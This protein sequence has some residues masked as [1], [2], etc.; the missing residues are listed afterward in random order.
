VSTM[1]PQTP[2]DNAGGLAVTHRPSS[3]GV[4][5]T[6][7][8]AGPRVRRHLRSRQPAPTTSP[9]RRLGGG[10]SGL[11]PAAG[12]ASAGFAL[13]AARAGRRAGGS[14]GR[15]AADRPL[16]L[17]R[18]SSRSKARRVAVATA[19][20]ALEC[21][22]P[23]PCRGAPG[24]RGDSA[25]RP[26]R[27][28]ADRPLDLEEVTMRAPAAAAHGSPRSPPNSRPIPRPRLCAR[29]AAASW[30]QPPLSADR[31]RSRRWGSRGR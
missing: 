8:P 19:L 7:S 9:G 22:P 21:E 3:T 29:S 14:A 16:G 26:W 15:G 28:R 17:A 25:P 6:C 20:R 18:P 4:P 12:M 30:T 2:P 13:K 11:G 27:G 24:Q 5:A 23:R 31:T 1:D 10:W